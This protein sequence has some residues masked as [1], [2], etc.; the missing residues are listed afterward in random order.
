MVGCMGNGSFHNG[1][2]IRMVRICPILPVRTRLTALKNVGIDRNSLSVRKTHPAFAAASARIRPWA[3]HNPIGFSQ[4]TS[5]PARM[6]AK[7][8]GTCQ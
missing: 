5:L 3:T 8:A 4:Q 6:A 7:A 1:T 2:D